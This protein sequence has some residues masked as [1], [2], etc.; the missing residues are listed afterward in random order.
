MPDNADS[1]KRIV[2]YA[3]FG[4]CAIISLIALLVYQRVVVDIAD[5]IRSIIVGVLALTAIFDVIM[6]WRFLSAANE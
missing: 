2:A 6:G 1:G 5:P 3:L 4:S